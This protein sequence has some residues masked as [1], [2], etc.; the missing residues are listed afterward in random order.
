[1]N[2]TQLHDGVFPVMLTPFDDDN[3][4]DYVSLE[5]L[6][7]WYINSGV[8][9]LFAACQ[10]SEISYLSNEE[11]FNLVK[12]VVDKVAGRVPV[13][14]SGH[15]ADELGQQ[16]LQLKNMVEAGANGIVLITNRLGPQYASDKQV[17]EHIQQLIEPLP[18]HISLGLYECP[19]P[20]KRLLSHPVLEWCIQSERF[21]FLKDTCC[22]AQV[23]RQRLTM[24]EDSGF[25]IFNA[26]GPTLLDSLQAGGAGY[27]GVMAN[28]YCDLYVWLCRHYQEDEQQVQEL[29]DFLSISSLAELIDYPVSA[30]YLQKQ[31]GNFST[32]HCRSRNEKSFYQDANVRLIQHLQRLAEHYRQQIRSN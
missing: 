18:D 7:N 21:T 28:Y 8:T 27:C 1:M 24:A 29:A 9:G 16:I 13:V 4:I 10:S 17:I 20:W 5:R 25:K 2:S 26:N 23:I 14:A 11:M 15:T 22:D 6:I 12:F 30:K 31:L 3:H 32:T 19:T